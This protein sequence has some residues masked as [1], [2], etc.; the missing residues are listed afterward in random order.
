MKKSTILLVGAMLISLISCSQRKSREARLSNTDLCLGGYFKEHQP[1]IVRFRENVFYVGNG[2]KIL[3]FNFT[4]GFIKEFSIPDQIAQEGFFTDFVPMDSNGTFLVSIN[5]GLYKISSDNGELLSSKFGELIRTDDSGNIITTFQDY[6]SVKNAVKNGIRF[7]NLNTRKQYAYPISD[8]L[9]A[10]NFEL[11][12]DVILLVAEDKYIYS[13]PIDTTKQVVTKPLNGDFERVLFL[14]QHRNY[15]V[16]LAHDY[17]TKTDK[18]FFY[19]VNFNFIAE[20]DLAL[21]LDELNLKVKGDDD[22]LTDFPSGNIYA[23]NKGQN[24]I[25][26]L[27]NKQIGPCLYSIEDNL[28]ITKGSLNLKE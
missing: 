23:Y 14:G 19:D 22:F 15:Y 7:F 25:Y 11:I 28:R 3:Q 2:Q 24:L 8:D 12:N 13:L 20:G 1:N 6:D 26:Y 16:T 17:K 10:Y 9:G 18:L 27:R 21:P 4:G 5:G